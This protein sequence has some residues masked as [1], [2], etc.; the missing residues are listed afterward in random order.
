MACVWYM[1]K[2]SIIKCLD[3]YFIVKFFVHSGT[4]FQI[5]LKGQ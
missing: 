4:D 1:Q 5:D 2:Y 3:V